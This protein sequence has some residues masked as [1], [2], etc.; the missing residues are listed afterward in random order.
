ME[1]LNE[2]HQEGEMS[3]GILEDHD[4]SFAM[5][6]V[7]YINLYSTKSVLFTK[8]ESS[9]IQRQT[10]ITYQIES[11]VDGNA[12]S[13]KIFKFLFPKVTVESLHKTK[14]NLVILKT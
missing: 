1:M 5:V 4:Q 10:K 11:G 13:F 14:N 12:M 3:P 9:T 7:K 8:V 6:R 2:G